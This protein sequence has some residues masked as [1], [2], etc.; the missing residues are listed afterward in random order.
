MPFVCIGYAATNYLGCVIT[1][2]DYIYPFL[3]WTKPSAYLI[4][5]LLWGAA[6]VFHYCTS[7]AC[8]YIQTY[9]K[10]KGGSRQ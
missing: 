6:F 4:C 7:V 2:R 9:F 5:V 1:G 3:N 10:L 8:W